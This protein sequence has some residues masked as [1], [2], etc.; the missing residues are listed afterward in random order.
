MKAKVET[1]LTSNCPELE[2]YCLTLLSLKGGIFR[3]LK[4][5]VEARLTTN[6]PYVEGYCLA[7]LS[8]KWGTLKERLEM[9]V[10]KALY[11]SCKEELELPTRTTISKAYYCKDSEGLLQGLLQ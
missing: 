3:I 6:C 9:D 10:D 2:G 8:L 11:F 4:A 5:K 7:L 1:K